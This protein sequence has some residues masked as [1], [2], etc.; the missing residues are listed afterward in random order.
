MSAIFITV[1]DVTRAIY[2]M[3]PFGRREKFDAERLYTS[4]SFFNLL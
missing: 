4:F 1:Y 2:P 3:R